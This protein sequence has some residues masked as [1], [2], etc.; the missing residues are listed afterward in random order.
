MN[1]EKRGFNAMRALKAMHSFDNSAAGAADWAEENGDPVV[2]RYLH[3]KSAMG[4]VTG[5][6][7]VMTAEPVA[8]ELG[9]Y[10]WEN[11]IAG[12]LYPSALVLPFET[13]VGAI[14]S[15]KADWVEA[16]H[17]ISAAAGTVTGAKLT[18]R[19]L[20]SIAVVTN[21]LLKLGTA[22]TEAALRSAL[23]TAAIAKL[24]ETLTGNTAGTVKAPAG[25]LQGAAAATKGIAAAIKAH[26]ALG[27][28]L[29]TTSLIAS[30]DFLFSLK[31]EERASLADLGIQIISNERVKDSF[32]VDASRLVM[33]FSGVDISTASAG[34]INTDPATGQS[35]INGNAPDKGMVS[36]FQTNSSALL[37]SAYLNWVALGKCVTAVTSA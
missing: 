28:T 8:V 6:A 7:L 10:I 21:E 30:T 19:K 14:A 5:D 32:L 12:K 26:S 9:N 13:P 22:G 11:S 1:C 17:Q 34:S 24:D 23:T 3:K 25:L 2:G 33:N 16:G 20:G 4:A 15:M 31:Q 29:A 36:L 18:P 37:L 35:V 27:A